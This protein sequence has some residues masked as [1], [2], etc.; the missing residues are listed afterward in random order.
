MAQLVERQPRDPVDS[1]TRRSNPVRSTRT[2]CE[3][4][5]E[6][7]CCADSSVCLTPVCIHMHK[8]DHARTQ[9]ILQSEFGGLRKHEKGPNMHFT[10]RRIHVLLYSTVSSLVIGTLSSVH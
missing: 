9:K 5:S 4:F 3:S 2:S 1:V 8:N 7:K 6:K 10:D